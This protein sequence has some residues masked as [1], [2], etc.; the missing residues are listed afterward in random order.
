MNRPPYRELQETRLHLQ[1]AEAELEDLEKQIRTFEAQV[2]TR[3]GVLLDQLSELNAETI[4]LDD[5]IR[6]IREQRL[7]GAELMSY[8]DGAPQPT[9]PP[10]LNDLPPMGFA[11]RS[12]IHSTVEGSVL[13][14]VEV[15]GIKVLYRKLA[16]R[17]HPDLARNAA[18]RLQSNQQMAE[19]NLAYNEGDLAKLMNLAGMV[20]PY[21]V[22][23]PPSSLIPGILQDK[24]LTD[25][26]KVE[27]KLKGIRQ[28]ITQLSNLPIVRLS[29]EVK[30]ARHQ[31]RDLLYEM[32]SELRYKV[33]RK[34]AERDYLKAQIRASGEFKA[35]G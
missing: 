5:R 24:S 31:G 3:L 13:A 35:D 21:G 22:E 28:Q 10:N 15:P 16:R 14:G 34:T 4:E 27:L 19:I 30:L 25:A 6:K 33:A 32:S 2:D 11:Q 17:Y 29:L 18:D 1:S 23:L 26:E 12:A 8:M 7:Y 20:T 9:R